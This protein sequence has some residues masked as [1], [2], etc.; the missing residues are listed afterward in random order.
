MVK[1]PKNDKGTKKPKVK[2]EMQ[3]TTSEKKEKGVKDKTKPSTSEGI[4][5]I[6]NFS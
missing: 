3:E 5:V 2:V 6:Y 1:S 4:N